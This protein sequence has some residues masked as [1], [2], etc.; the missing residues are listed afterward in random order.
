M[1]DEAADAMGEDADADGAE[2]ADEE[3]DFDVI[4][5]GGGM[6]GAATALTL[7]QRGIEG[8]RI[9]LIDRGEPVGAKNLSGG[10]LW[11]REL[12]HFTDILGDWENEGPFERHITNKR[13]GMLSPEDSL[14]IDGRFAS[15]S[16]EGDTEEPSQRCAWS[17]LRARTDAWLA[18]KL[19][20]AGVF[21][22]AGIMVDQLHIKGVDH[23]SYDPRDLTTPSNSSGTGAAQVWKIDDTPELADRI[24]HGQIAG[25]VQD[26]EVMTARVVVL[27]DGSNSV[28]ARAYDFAPMRD[29]QDKH[30][31]LLGVKEVIELG[32]D[33]INDRFGCAP[34]TDERP[35]SGM[36][37]EATLALF[38]DMAEQAWKKYPETTGK[39]PKVGGFLYTNRSN[40]S[41]GV[42]IQLDSLPQGIHTYDLY[43]GFKQHPAIEPLWRGG[44]AI[45]YGGH[46]VPEWGPHR[47]PR[48]YVRHGALVVG[49]AAGLVFS[50]GMVIQG[51]NYALISGRL[52][53]DAIAMALKS[54]DS[55][56]AT[57]KYYESELK[58]SC[59]FR[60]F[61]RFKKMDRFLTDDATFTWMPRAAGLMFN[62]ALRE[63]GEEKVTMQKQ[64]F[65][66]RKD[67]RSRN[68]AYK[69]GLGLIGLMRYGWRARRM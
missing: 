56:V 47:A 32:E 41:V 51:M 31:M 44:E 6:A 57:L 55:S 16:G 69:K 65:R 13:V 34:G 28:L 26:G 21:V 43:Q 42:V 7:L 9:L 11:G 2:D 50:N 62:R 54:K 27:A 30:G 40:L 3:T 48:R 53:G 59:I 49:D 68:K 25:I 23:T 29:H 61:K 18:E 63:I 64:A 46:L 36:A 39:M 20:E 35:P 10:V 33:I 8:E 52:A 19:E 58:D 67:L 17:V 12:D 38:E 37:M 14:V 66:I 15:W 1:S 22:M 24:H 60:D 4:I 45:E 5:I